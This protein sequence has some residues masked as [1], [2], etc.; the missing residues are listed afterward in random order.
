MSR[1]GDYESDGRYRCLCCGR[2]QSVPSDAGR[3]SEYLSNDYFNERPNWALYFS[4]HHGVSK[5]GEQVSLLCQDRGTSVKGT[6]LW[7][8]VEYRVTSTG[9]SGAVKRGWVTDANVKTGTSGPVKGVKQGNCPDPVTRIKAGGRMNSG[10]SLTSPGAYTL[11]MQSD[12]NLVWNASTVAWSSNTHIAGS[13]VR[14]QTDGNLV[15]YTP[16]NRALWESG[17]SRHPG[18]YLDLQADGNLLIYY[19]SPRTAIWPSRR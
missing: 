19:G 16:S 17:T 6:T 12:G 14:M 13:Y 1:K 7:D 3:G 4:A 9:I 11:S 18:A 5:S 10:K 8:F 15:V 2:K